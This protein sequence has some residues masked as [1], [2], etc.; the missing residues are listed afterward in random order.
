MTVSTRTGFH[1]NNESCHLSI[2]A[3]F[4]KIFLL[5][6]GNWAA[7]SAWGVCSL[8]CN[9]GSQTRTRSCIN[10]TNGGLRICPSNGAPSES[11]VCNTN[12]CPCKV[13]SLTLTKPF[14]WHAFIV[15]FMYFST[16]ATSDFQLQRKPLNV[17]TG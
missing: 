11:Q 17:I 14:D 15:F 3:Q 6:D 10:P 9:S 2:K 12:A 5:V 1:Q 16:P 13:F 8:L 7:W 4:F